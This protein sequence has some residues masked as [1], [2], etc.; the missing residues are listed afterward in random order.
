MLA[1]LDLDLRTSALTAAEAGADA[2]AAGA[3]L[4]GLNIDLATRR[5]ALLGGLSGPAIK[6]IALRLF[7]DVARIVHPA[8]PH[9][10]LIGIGGITSVYD[11]LKFILAGACA[12]QL[13]TINCVNPRASV[14]IV[15]GLEAWLQ[16][17]GIADISEIT[18]AALDENATPDQGES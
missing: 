14:A 1:P 8:Y 2:L 10:S 12:I 7:Y 3:S 16:T 6:L 9:V 17:Q 18:S 13:G 11:A 15:E 4:P 5:S